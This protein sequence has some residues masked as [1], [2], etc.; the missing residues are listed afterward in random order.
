MKTPKSKST[1]PMATGIPPKHLGE[2]INRRAYEIWEACGCPHGC[3][4]EHW[5]QAERE[6]RELSQSS[7]GAL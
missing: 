7:T 6:V 2:H 5:L 1:K 3:D 4:T